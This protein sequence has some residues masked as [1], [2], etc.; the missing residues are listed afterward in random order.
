[1][2]NNA[3]LILRILRHAEHASHPISFSPRQ[4]GTLDDLESASDIS[5][6]D[7]SMNG[8]LPQDEEDSSRRDPQGLTKRVMHGLGSRMHR[9]ADSSR[10]R[11][12]MMWDKV[13]EKKEASAAVLAGH[14][15]VDVA[16]KA[17]VSH[18]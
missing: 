16:G 15:E 8:H 17:S 1:M 6:K 3:Q 13:G 4:E 2:P 10:A 9:M 11:V 18:G 12:R 5:M 14:R 7:G